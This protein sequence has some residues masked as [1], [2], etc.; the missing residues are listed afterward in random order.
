MVKTPS[1]YIVTPVHNR[2]AVTVAYAQLLSRQTLQGVVLVLVDDGSTDGTAEAVQNALPSTVVLR[3]DGNL[4][5]AGGL[6]KGLNW[7]AAQGLSDTTPVAFMNDDTAFDDD[8]LERVVGELVGL[9]MGQFLTVPGLFLPSGRRSEEA[10][11]CDWPR[12]RY[13][14]YGAH[15]ERID[16]TSTRS[17][18]MRWAD[19]RRVGGFHPTT[20]PHYVSDYEFTIRAH[21]RGI[22][23]V[24]AQSAVARF[25]DLATGNHATKG[26]RLGAK[27]RLLLSPRFSFNPIA[28][29]LYVWYSCPLVWKVPCW[30]RILVSTVKFL[31]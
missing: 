29:F 2:K 8:Y 19:L 9:P 15:P 25:D 12:F 6:Q 7:L 31:R 23:L 28:M 22:R 13:R 20:L 1:L 3:G 21:R 14:D 24:P 26:R 10:V 17:L 11:V 5:W 18:F 30:A 16:C 4:W 27:V